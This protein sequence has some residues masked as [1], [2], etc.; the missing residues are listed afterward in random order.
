MNRLVTVLL[1]AAVFIISERPSPALAATGA[2]GNGQFVLA[3]E[4]EG[5]VDVIPVRQG[6]RDQQNVVV[7]GR[8]GGK[9]NPWINGAAAFLLVDRSLESCDEKGHNCPTP[10]DFCC[11]NLS[12]SMVLVMFVDETGRVVRQDARQLLG[13]KELDTVV[14]EGKAK[15]DNAGTV[16]IMASRIYVKNAAEVS[17]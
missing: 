2:V 12:K 5:A 4:P 15:R 7:V 17:Q 6:V 8:I 16:S 14:V 3:E 1:L 13:V 9:K 11:S 10:W